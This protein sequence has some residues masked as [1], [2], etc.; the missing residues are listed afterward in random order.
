M[1][2]GVSR[3]LSTRAGGAAGEKRARAR[4][5]VGQRRPRL[6][7]RSD[8]QLG[9]YSAGAISRGGRPRASEDAFVL[10]RGRGYRRRVGERRARPS[11]DV[12]VLRLRAEERE[13]A[14]YP[15]LTH[16][17]PCRGE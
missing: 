6:P 11:D 4:T 2:Q 15:R 8:H 12:L 1:S 10:A 17:N 5:R 3:R 9:A 16:H 7:R 14:R 13:R